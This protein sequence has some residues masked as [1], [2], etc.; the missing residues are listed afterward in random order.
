M[1][2]GKCVDSSKIDLFKVLVLFK[3]LCFVS[4]CYYK[5]E[6]ELYNWLSV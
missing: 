2:C 6:Q 5:P 3:L 1:Q 4:N